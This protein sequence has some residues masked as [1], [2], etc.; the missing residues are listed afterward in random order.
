MI[1]RQLKLAFSDIKRDIELHQDQINSLKEKN[2]ELR[3]RIRKLEEEKVKSTPL[4]DDIAKLIS[5]KALS[6]KEIFTR[7][8][9]KGI[10]IHEKSVPRAI[11]SLLKNGRIRKV[12]DGKVFKYEIS[13]KIE[14]I[15]DPIIYDRII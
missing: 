14:S 1:D 3:K 8:Y 6:S 10:K 15:E 9:D 13:S 7:L 2:E 5:D 11:K 4:M 12:K